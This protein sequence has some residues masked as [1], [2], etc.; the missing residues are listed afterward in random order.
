MCDKNLITRFQL[1]T[2]SQLHGLYYRLEEP[3]IIDSTISDILGFR[4]S[5]KDSYQNFTVPK[6]YTSDLQSIII[7]YG[8]IL[9]HHKQ[10]GGNW[11]DFQTISD[12]VH[13][14]RH[15]KHHPICLAI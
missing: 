7:M 14:H 15:L 13:N 9:C 12:L 2:V 11:H 10:A 5:A 6:Q 1:L 8:D 3:I 4:H